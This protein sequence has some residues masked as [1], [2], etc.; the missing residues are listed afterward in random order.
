MPVARQRLAF[1]GNSTLR[2]GSLDDELEEGVAKAALARDGRDP[3]LVDA[4]DVVVPQLRDEVTDDHRPNVGNGDVS[5][6]LE[7]P[8]RPPRTGL[9]MFDKPPFSP[10]LPVERRTALG[11][12]QHQLGNVVGIVRI[13]DAYIGIDHGNDDP[14]R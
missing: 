2:S 10:A 5:S 14:T 8:L 6:G 7:A 4:Q 1:H 13:G 9:G 3:N 11:L 12:E